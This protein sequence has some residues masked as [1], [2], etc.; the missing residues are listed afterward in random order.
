MGP[1]PLVL[2]GLIPKDKKDQLQLQQD[3]KR[4]YWKGV[5]FIGVM[6]VTLVITF[7]ESIYEVYFANEYRDDENKQR[8]LKRLMVGH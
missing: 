1:L 6:I 7:A 4:H 2:L 5:A 3:T 8:R